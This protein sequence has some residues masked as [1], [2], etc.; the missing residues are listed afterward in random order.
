MVAFVWPSFDGIGHQFAAHPMVFGS[1]IVMSTMQFV[2]FCGAVGIWLFFFG[3]AKKVDAFLNG[4]PE[5]Q[6]HDLEVSEKEVNR[7]VQQ[8]ILGGDKPEFFSRQGNTVFK[9]EQHSLQRRLMDQM[10]WRQA[11]PGDAKEL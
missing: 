10:G 3:G 11:A 7:L 2:C 4:T 9:S 8:R 1:I 5:E 6:A